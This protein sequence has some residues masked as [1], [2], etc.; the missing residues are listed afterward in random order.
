MKTLTIGRGNVN[1][2]AYSDDGRFLVTLNSGKR[3]RFW[4]LATFSE[5]LAFTLPER[6]GYFQ[7]AFCLHGDL[8]VLSDRGW[9]LGAAWDCLA[10][11]AQRPGQ[12]C[13]PSSAPVAPVVLEHKTNV[14]ILAGAADGQ[15][16]AGV[17]GAHFAQQVVGRH[18]VVWNQQG[19][20]LRRFP[21]A[22]M[23]MSA[24]ALSP[25]GQ[26]LAVPDGGLRPAVL[27]FD[28]NSGTEVGRLGLTN[29]AQ[30]LA[31]SPNG[32]LLACAAGRTVRLWDVA[33]LA[34]LDRFPAFQ[35]HAKALAFHP[36][37]QLLGAGS[38]EGEVRLWDT[39]SHKQVACLDWKI[40]AVNGLAFAPDGMTVAAAGHNGTIVVWDLE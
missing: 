2:L 15:S 17:T 12:R 10:Q 24:L 1:A 40:G 5:R 34:L 19:R 37:S 27:F 28:R 21:V 20:C 23:S 7:R 36:N 33:N 13:R 31:F 26:L 38:R 6:G 4:D 18:L 22:D 32:R 29:Q 8:L 35:K 9:D 11:S 30:R 3:L 14:M 16:L 25:D 39:S